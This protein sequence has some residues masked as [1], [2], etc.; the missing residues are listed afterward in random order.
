MCSGTLKTERPYE[1]AH[2]ERQQPATIDLHVLALHAH[3]LATRIGGISRIAARILRSLLG[4]R[5]E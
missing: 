5:T 4:I 1:R 2:P 3:S